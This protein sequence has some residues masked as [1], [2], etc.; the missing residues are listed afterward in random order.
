MF[1]RAIAISALVLETPWYPLPICQE[2]L[3]AGLL[4]DFWVLREAE[5]GLPLWPSL[6][7][8]MPVGKPWKV[9]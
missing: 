8:R 2:M 6:W 5:K 3:F 7:R 4:Q 1:Q 9:E